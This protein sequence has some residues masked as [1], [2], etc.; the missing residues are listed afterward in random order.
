MPTAKK[1]MRPA[2]RVHHS[3][4]ETSSRK[5]TLNPINTE[6]RC[7]CGG[8]CP[9]CTTKRN[10]QTTSAGSN[11]HEHE[12]KAVGQSVMRA[13]IPAVPRNMADGGRHTDKA[14]K[15]RV[16]VNTRGGLQKARGPP[17]PRRRTLA[18]TL[19]PV[20]SGAA[21]PLTQVE[22]ER[23]E[24]LFGYDLRHVRLYGG[25]PAEVAAEQEHAHAFTHG[26]N[27]FLSRQVQQAPAEQ[28]LAVIAHELV[29]VCQQAGNLAANDNH[30]G[31]QARGPPD[32]VFNVTAAPRQVMRLAEDDDSVLPAFLTDAASEVAEFATDTASVVVDE[33]APGLMDFLRG[34]AFGQLTEMF[35]GGINSLLESLFS[36]LGNID[37]MSAI[38][39][40]FTSLATGVRGVQAAIGGAASA[41]VGAVVGPLV[42]ALKVW[43]GPLVETVKSAADAVNGV[44]STIWAE[45]AVP[46]LGILERIGGAVW[47]GFNDLVAWVWDLIEPI[48]NG[49]ETAWEWLLETFD[50]AWESSSGIRDWLAETADS[51]WKSF[52]E[53]IEPIRGPLETAAKVAVLVSPLGPIVVLAKVIP[54]LWEK[55][56]WLWNNWNSEDILV[57]ARETLQNDILPGIIG[58]VSSIATA[59]GSAATWLADLVSE[60]GSA[61]SGVQGVFGGSSCLSAVVTYLDGVAAQFERLSAWAQ[62]GFA[63]LSGAL[64]AVFDALVA[65]FQPVLDFLVRLTLV[66]A[67]PPLLPIAISGAIWLLCPPDLKPPVI[68]F[69]LDLLIAFIDGS[70]LILAGLGPMAIVLQSGVLGFLREL[71]G[72]AAMVDQRK[73]DA[74][75]KIANLA[76]GGGIAF[77]SGFAVG[78]LHGVID[79]IIDPFRL[80]FLI[81][82][83]LVAG[84]QAIKRIFNPVVPADASG[85]T[86]TVPGVK[87]SGAV[88]PSTG[89]PGAVS[90][91]VESSS[92]ELPS[93]V[94]VPGERS[95][96]EIAASMGA[97]TATD[98]IA[99]TAEAG[100]DDA[101][102]STDMRGEMETEGSSVRGL[103][104]LLGDAWDWVMQGSEGLGRSAANAFVEFIL[105]PDYQLGRKLGFV[106][107][108]IALQAL[109]IYLTAGGYAALEATAPLWRQLLALFLRFLDLGGEILGVIGKALKPLKG[110]LLA[111]LG[112][113]R[114]FL[115]K[116]RFARGLIERIERLAAKMFRFGDD[117][118][119]AATR[120]GREATEEGGERLA[121]EGAEE[122]GERASREAGEEGAERGTR[123]TTSEAADL[124]RKKA[125]EL[126]EAL[127]AA[128]AITTSNDVVN[129]PAPALLLQLMA[130]RSRF[131]WI[132]GFRVTPMAMPGIFSVD[133]LASV[134]NVTPRYN[135]LP[136]NPAEITA[137]V[138]ALRNSGKITAQ[139]RV[140]RSGADTVASQID[141]MERRALAGDIGAQGEIAALE[142][143]VF[144][145]GQTVELIPASDIPGRTR[146]DVRAPAQGPGRQLADIK[147]T[148]DARSAKGWE[149]W[150]KDQISSVNTQ[151]KDSALAAGR[152]GAAEFQLFGPASG[153]LRSQTP[154]DVLRWVRGNFNEG[155]GRDLQRVS[156]FADG[157][158][159]YEF[160]RAGDGVV[161][162]T[163]P[164]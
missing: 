109:I 101:A 146:P 90:A 70:T 46:A 96:S 62:S 155:R 16:L 121:R 86:D 58:T 41:A 107:G 66:F 122:T 32:Q 92:E 103:A 75:N 39:T 80:I 148:V 108:F 114:V 63:G 76:A 161:T 117:A 135:T 2:V 97:E 47:Q 140:G 163:F 20:V 102:L 15:G 27:I 61:M 158:L 143:K 147:T 149:R 88:P 57:L 132:D 116:F 1:A 48:R 45:L 162:R 22:R 156:I 19:S 128:R 151:I 106:T 145:Q 40:T 14:L 164:P 91:G 137:R 68:N 89:P 115:S 60:F 10:S 9:R 133:M 52:Q 30:I 53:T 113:A 100:I 6:K 118:A 56:T 73:I 8:G 12:A 43:G 5:D 136:T 21:R 17:A 33:L 159:L 71:R 127:V 81:G 141:D 11:H 131:R 130:L 160:T 124:A 44:F 85:A 125:I 50:L 138:G 98:I 36:S 150:I 94:A 64:Q 111:G 13:A 42:E 123:E 82:Q 129:T 95:D 157:S 25:A 74:S 72:G 134:H 153:S 3:E 38:E 110:P 28:R 93:L 84:A 119:A 112:A 144:D 126:P 104:R 7:A 77:I 120:G 51:A 67:N 87:E 152:P 31:Y 83:A 99:E 35:C 29:H 26:S 79:G 23:F 55:I 59:I 65:I 24:P 34:G 49:A 4:T 18:A 142:R 154:D 105:L 37:I 54:P 139:S 69:I 78:F